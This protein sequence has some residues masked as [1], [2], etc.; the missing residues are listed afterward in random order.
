M[1]FNPDVRS[2]HASIKEHMDTLYRAVTTPMIKAVP[3]KKK[4]LAQKK[5]EN[6]NN[7]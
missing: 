5:K 4:I 1:K 6:D 7:R 3:K 2:L